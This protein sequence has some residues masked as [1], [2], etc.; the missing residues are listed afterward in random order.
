[1]KNNPVR[2]LFAEPDER[3]DLLRLLSQ[4]LSDAVEEVRPN[5]SFLRRNPGKLKPGFHQAYKRTA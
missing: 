1:M 2:R 3:G 5:R 4:S